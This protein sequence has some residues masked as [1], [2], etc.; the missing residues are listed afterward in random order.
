MQ[1]TSTPSI[2]EFDPYVIPYQHQVIQ[3]IRARYDFTLGT[4]EV[5]LS[6]SV[7]SAKSILIAH[8]VVTHCLFNQGARF[9]IGR[10]SMPALRATLFTKILEH[11]GNDLKEGRDFF[12]NQT[13][14]SIRFSNGSEIIS[15]S[16]A[17][18]KFF[19]VRSLELSG[20]AIEELVES[21]EMDFYNEIKMRV[22]RLPHVKEN[23]IINAT[24]PSDPSHWAYKYFI[25]SKKKTRHVYYSV[26]TD[27]PFLP[28]QYIA[29]LRNDLDQKMV[30]RMIYGKWIEIAGEIIYYAYDKKH[31]FIDA[32]YTVNSNYPVILSW[33]FNIGEGKPMSMCC[34]QYINDTFHVFAEVI[35]NGARTSDTLEELHSKGL[36]DPAYKFQ[37][38][39]DASGKH[40]DTRSSKSDY[41]IIIHE[42]SKRGIKFDYLVPL[43]NP[44]IRSRHN[45]LNAYCLNDLGVRRLFVYSDCKTVDEGLR[46]TKLKKGASYIED[47]SKPYQHVTTSLGYAVMAITEHLNRKPQRTIQ[48]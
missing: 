36:L 2:T 30:E 17:D 26:T 13:T 12:V 4:H 40:R 28:P 20:A 37:I 48:L 10:L 39:G 41:D 18:R 9:L 34:M 42:L 43:A 27:N 47:D 45:R 22:G 3:D 29:Q 14:A 1:N 25:T 16:W 23:I 6:G 8:I 33:D 24:N 44:P 7:G 46:L 38:C 31:N 19:K 21:E 11:I 15:R 35:I 5:L 32:K